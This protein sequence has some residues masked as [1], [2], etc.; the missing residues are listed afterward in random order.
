MADLAGV[1]NTQAAK[2]TLKQAGV[3]KIPLDV[4]VDRQGRPVR[5]L[6]TFT[7]KGQTLTTDF[8][9]SAINQPVTIAAP[10][11]SQ[12]STR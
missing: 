12:V 4:W 6:E 9:I 2:A 11:A 3:M 7:V 10:P 1:I 8:N 5:L